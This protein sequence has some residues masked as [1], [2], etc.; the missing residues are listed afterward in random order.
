MARNQPNTEPRS[1]RMRDF[2]PLREK[3][4]VTHR[5]KRKTKVPGLSPMSID[6]PKSS[7]GRGKQSWPG[8]ATTPM[9]MRPAHSC[10]ETRPKRSESAEHMLQG[11]LG[12]WMRRL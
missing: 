3:A 1:A 11:H 7:E 9:Q 5:R 12:D 2:D 10:L 8:A 4:R 6:S